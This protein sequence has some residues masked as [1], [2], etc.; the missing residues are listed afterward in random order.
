M[1]ARRDCG[2]VKV[3]DRAASYRKT[4]P[5]ARPV[6]PRQD[7][8]VASGNDG[9]Y[10][11]AVN[12]L[13]TLFGRQPGRNKRHPISVAALR[14]LLPY[15][16]RY[17]VRITIMLVLLLVSSGLSLVL[18]VLGGHIVDAGFVTKNLGQVG[19]WGWAAIVISALMAIASA[20]RNYFVSLLGER[21]LTDLRTS[22]FNHLL[23]LDA[24]FFDT[25]RV[26]DLTSRL[27]G[28][29]AVI[30]GIV[31][32]TMST[33]LRSSLQLTGAVILMFWTSPLLALGVIIVVPAIMFPM[34]TLGRRIRGLS[35]RTQDALAEMSAMATEALGATRTVKSFVQEFEQSRLFTER[36]EESYEAQIGQIGVRAILG[37]AV[38]F[39]ATTLLIVLAWWGSQEVVNG[40]VTAGQLTQFLIYAFM[41]VGAVQGVSDILGTF[42]SISGATER[43]IEILDTK[44]RL[45]VRADP[46]PF[47]KPAIGTVAF[48]HVSF[49]YHTREHVAVLED[50][51]F[52]VAPGE[53]VALVGA[54]GAGKSTAF[55]LIQRFYDVTGG[56]IL[57]DGVDVRDADIQEVRRHFSYVEQEPIIFAGSIRDNIRFGR[58]EAT[59]AEIVEAGKAALVHDFV[60]R[61]DNG[62]SSIV[63]ERGILL[64]G[65]QK[66]RL[67][68]AR[69]LL[70][71]APFLLLDEATSA[72]DAE[73]ERLVQLA[74]ERL[75]EGRTTLIIAHRLATIRDADRIFVME[76]GR[77]VDQGRHDDLVRRGGRYAELAKLQFRGEVTQAAE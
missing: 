62:Y 66:Q 68:I 41:A 31:G 43:L 5:A 28:D 4:P 63:G 34:M 53:T 20:G 39:I 21:I 57:V 73:S 48:E 2:G 18:P 1:G 22:V 74:L 44:S 29:V 16:L 8:A 36:A 70:K 25:H 46:V 49:A 67:A 59:E 60:S 26:G 30:R 24:S 51:D 50:V 54:S 52:V 3:D 77:L 55:S 32:G 33:I 40:T 17:R 72:L 10:T 71:N 19:N 42:S 65:G 75:K 69:A 38:N 15:I 47:P 13:K 45:P 61:L 56:R 12:V 27:N 6:P 14:R 35:R 58:P 76:Q 23:G 64:S 37:A 9:A 7:E 11:G